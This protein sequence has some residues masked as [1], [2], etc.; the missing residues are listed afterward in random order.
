MPIISGLG[1]GDANVLSAFNP[2]NFLSST[3]GM[4]NQNFVVS[5]YRQALGRQP[6]SSEIAGWVQAL[7]S[8]QSRYDVINQFVNSPEFY[9]TAKNQSQDTGRVYLQTQGGGSGL[10]SSVISPSPTAQVAA[11]N[12]TTASG[13]TTGTSQSTMNSLT[14]LFSGS[15]SIGGY[16]VPTLALVGGGLAL[17]YFMSK[18]R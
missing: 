12:A 14:N 16:S 18:R 8:G 10:V 4:D 5:L 13:D 7:T 6:V 11:A 17:W 9:D 3:G 2:Y 1:L 15:T